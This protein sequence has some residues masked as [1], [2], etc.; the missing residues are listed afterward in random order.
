MKIIHIFIIFIFLLFFCISSFRHTTISKTTLESMP[1]GGSLATIWY[2]GSDEKYHYLKH[3]F[4]MTKFYK[5]KK[6][7]VSL[8][9]EFPY[10]SQS[11]INVKRQDIL[12]GTH[13]FIPLKL[14]KEILSP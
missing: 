11:A 5:I 4:K 10:K 1:I 14:K 12:T 9:F 8:G 7:T 6:T 2:E 13:N 3:L